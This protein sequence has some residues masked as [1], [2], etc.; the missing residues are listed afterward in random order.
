MIVARNLSREQFELL[1][2]N[3]PHLHEL[4]LKNGDLIYS[5]YTVHRIHNR[6]CSVFKTL[7][8]KYNRSDE[9]GVK[10]AYDTDAMVDYSELIAKAGDV[11]ITNSIRENDGKQ[12]PNVAN[13]IGYSSS[14]EKL[15]NIDTVRV[16]IYRYRK[17]S[18]PNISR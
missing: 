8:D 12:S 2:E 6:L 9:H 1:V 14:L 5:E 7:V 11:I 17:F 3:N 13:E 10:L 15:V 16:R 18:C 4:W